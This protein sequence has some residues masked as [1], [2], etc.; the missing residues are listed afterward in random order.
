MITVPQ[1]EIKMKLIIENWKNYL[2]G[3]QPTPTKSYGV[4]P[5]RLEN[6]R[7]EFLIGKPPNTNYW[8]V[9]KGLLDDIDG[10]SGRAAA[11]R[12]FEEETG[13]AF[14]PQIQLDDSKILTAVVGKGKRQKEL[15][16]WLVEMP[17]L[18]IVNFVPN[19]QNTIDDPKPNRPKGEQAPWWVGEPEIV[20]IE[21][22]TIETAMERVYSSQ[23]PLFNQVEEKL[24]QDPGPPKHSEQ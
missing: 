1:Q 2:E 15:K 17:D 24:N 6:D 18:S 9:F 19:K 22:V 13:L 16:I 3:G 11:M 7:I 4:L 5:W 8:T 10:N 12:E 21:W 23:K 14:S 20:K